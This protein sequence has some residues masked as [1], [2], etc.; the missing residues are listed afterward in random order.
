M[1]KALQRE[2][3]F[4]IFDLICKG[5]LQKNYEKCKVFP[6]GSQALDTLNRIIVY[7]LNTFKS[8]IIF[9]ESKFK[10]GKIIDIYTVI[11]NLMHIIANI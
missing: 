11:F 6:T 3:D 7:K 9:F 8:K 4:R 1:E 5:P 2:F 10:T